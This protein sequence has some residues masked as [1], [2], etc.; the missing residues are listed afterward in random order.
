MSEMESRTRGLGQLAVFGYREGRR[1]PPRA[2]KAVC[3]EPVIRPG[4]PLIPPGRYMLPSGGPVIP[5]DETMTRVES[6]QRQWRDVCQG[7]LRMSP[8]AGEVACAKPVIPLSVTAVLGRFLQQQRGHRYLA[9]LRRTA[10]AGETARA[11]SVIPP[12][13]TMARVMRYQREW[14]SRYRGALRRCLSTAE[15]ASARGALPAETMS[16]VRILQRGNRQ[17]DVNLPGRV[18]APRPQVEKPIPMEESERMRWIFRDVCKKWG[19]TVWR[20]VKEILTMLLLGKAALE[21]FQ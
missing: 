20:L 5:P 8:S 13:E 12:G 1:R 4:E 19:I 18:D 3:A 16:R 21:I 9:R 14:R 6:L 11:G 7:A 15:E 17:P 10:G 2:V